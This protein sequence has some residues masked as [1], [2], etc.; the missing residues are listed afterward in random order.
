MWR[1]KRVMP[2]D[3]RVSYLGRSR[4]LRSAA[5][6]LAAVTFPFDRLFV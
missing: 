3:C 4:S 5:R 6:N 1:E 2:S